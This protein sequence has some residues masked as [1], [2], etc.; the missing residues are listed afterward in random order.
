M[1]IWLFNIAMENPENT[2][3]FPAGKII[4]FYGPSSMAM[5]NNQRVHHC[6]WWLIP[7]FFMG[8]LPP[9]GASRSVA[10]LSSHPWSSVLLAA[11]SPQPVMQDMPR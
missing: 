5:L 9:F 8:F 2:W 10:I 1:T 7:L 4:Y 6:F 11:K 3:R